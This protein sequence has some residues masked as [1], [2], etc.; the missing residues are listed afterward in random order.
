MNFILTNWKTSLGGLILIVLGA[1]STFLGVKVPGFT[2]DFGTAFVAGI[3]LLTAKDG[4]VSGT[5]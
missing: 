3:A 4:N 5:G 1:L 2:M